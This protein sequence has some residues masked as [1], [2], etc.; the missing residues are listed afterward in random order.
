M[1]NRKIRQ[2]VKR[3]FNSIKKRLKPEA[4]PETFK[5]ALKKPHSLAYQLIG[6]KT[7]R[8]LPFFEDLGLDMQ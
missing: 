4:S 3:F 7:D 6:E 1:K 5:F 8:G 2:R